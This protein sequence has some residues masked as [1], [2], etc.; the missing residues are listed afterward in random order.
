MAARKPNLIIFLP[1]QQRADTLA[2]YGGKKVHAANLNKLASESV[3]FERAYVTHP[4]CTP[5]RSSL[6]TGTWPHIN[7]CTRNSVPLDRRFRVFPEL[8]E[9]KD[10]R[11][12]YMG[13]WH[14]GNEGPAR[15]GFGE[16]ISTEHPGDYTNFL[17]STG[18]TAD[19]QSGA[20]SELAISKLPLELSRPKFLEKHACEFIEKH[21]CDPF[22]LVVAFVEPHSPYN[23]PLNNEHPLEEI[24]L[25]STA[26][27]PE[28]ENIPLRYRLMREWQ[29][30][31][32]AL[33]RERLPTQLFFGITPEEYRSIKQRYL[34]LITLV[35]KSIGAIL[36]CLE[37]CGLSDD[38]IVVHTSDHGDSL[39]AHHLFGK[40][41]MFEEAARVPLLVR[42][43]SQKRGKIV[44]QSVSHIDF[45]PTLLD[46]LGQPKHPQCAGR[47]LLPLIHEE[48]LPPESVFIEWAP[49]R[50]KIK[51]GTSL[52]PRRTIE[53]AVDESTRAVVSADGWKFCVRDKDL[54]ELYN[55]H[56]D[57]LETRN[58]YSDRQY[59]SV[60][61]RCAGEIHRWQ[62]STDD[63]LKL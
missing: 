30:A 26:T 55:L 51:K 7:G 29:Q 37:R 32:A 23:G 47:S 34:G 36:G 19:K 21:R 31:E 38:T 42:L 54:N 43:H 39:G 56:D 13:K 14:L 50:T 2:C 16:W 44:P 3:V 11:T 57:P 17:L 58:L 48:A 41:V 6:M 24:D 53:R 20:F 22:I 25:D 8:M 52:A 33:D 49:N 46:L 15:R 18:L 4:V 40:E 60:I 9:D 59:A 12:A 63:K 5:S 10:H 1:D 28:S 45:V 35:D 62:E 27:L 61:S